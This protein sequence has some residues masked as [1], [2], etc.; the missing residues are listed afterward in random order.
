[1]NSQ[2]PKWAVTGEPSVPKVAAAKKVE[3]AVRA[4]SLA[5]V[6]GQYQPGNLL[7]SESELGRLYQVSR[8]MVREALSRL[9]NLG[10]VETRHGI[11]SIV[12]PPIGWQL[13]EPLL[14][15]LI[16]DSGH[17]PDIGHELVELRASI[18]VEAARCAAKSITDTQLQ[19]VQGWL[20]RMDACLQDDVEEF[21]RADVAFHNL[22]VLSSGNRF[23]VQIMN[24]LAYPLITARRIT[25]ELGGLRSRTEAQMWHQQ[26]YEAIVTRDATAAADA[27]RNHMS[28]L[29]SV[30]NQALAI[31]A[32]NAAGS[33][34]SAGAE[35]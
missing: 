25:S 24:K 9:A 1:M 2:A 28:Q 12:K 16:I 30:I 35:P 3:V 13:L 32:T 17:M 14:L 27:M 21:A 4:M 29:D 26:I 23:F 15:Q 8:P 33:N 11:G 20:H 34:I 22:I 18:E 31:M 6:Q 5:I 19:Q 7:P 10:L